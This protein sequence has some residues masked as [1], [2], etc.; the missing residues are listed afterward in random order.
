MRI[1]GVDPSLQG[2]D[3]AGIVIRDGWQI[4]DLIEITKTNDTI[5]LADQLAEIFIDFGVDMMFIDCIGNGAGVFHILK[6]RFPGKV[7]GVDVST[8]T[9]DKRKR[10]ARLRDELY[11]KVRESFEQNLVSIPPSTA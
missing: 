7:R 2:G 9:T 1:M 11:W 5:E 6:R 4:T 8:K 10:Y 3:P